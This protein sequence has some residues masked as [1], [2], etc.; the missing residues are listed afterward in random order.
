MKLKAIFL[1]FNGVLVISFLLIFLMPLFLLGADSFSLFWG[2]H[3]IIALVFLVTL[4]AVNGYFG[5]NW[6]LFINLE[7]EDWPAL[8]VFLEDRILRRGLA[9]PTHVR[10]LLN[11]YLITSNTEGILAL[12]AFLRR[13]SPR[14]ISRFSIPFG[15]PYLLMKDPAVSEAFF[16]S[17]L[18]AGAPANREWVRWNRSFSLIQM[19]RPQDARGELSA[20]SGA[21]RDPVVRLLSLY[22]LDVLGRGDPA[23]ERSVVEGRRGLRSAYSAQRL[24]QVIERSAD[25]MEIVVLS[26]IVADAR[27]WLYAEIPQHSPPG[28]ASAPVGEDAPGLPAPEDSGQI[29]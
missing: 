26:K 27:L 29:H 18:A 12:E 17:L 28:D 20:L 19:G 10:M 4:A 14:L 24:Q 11:A 7:K 15:I 16:A 9:W 22:L 21:A 6:K 1:L 23:V 13:R 5:F 25:N 8:V 3:W 2:G